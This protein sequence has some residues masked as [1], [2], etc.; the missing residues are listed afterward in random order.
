VQC[1]RLGIPCLTPSR[2]STPEFCQRLAELEPDFLVVAAFGEIL[3]K[4][5]LDIARIAPINVHASLLP[6]LRGAAPINWALIRGHGT[7]GIT[8]FR[9]DEG[10]DTGDIL[11][12]AEVPIGPRETA[13]QLSAKLS[14]IAPA[15]L[16]DT[17][18]GMELGT[19]MPAP[20]D[21]LCATYAPKLSKGNGR[22]DWELRA[23]EVDRFIR[24]VTPWPGAL[25]TFRSTPV[26]I[27]RAAPGPPLQTQA[28]PGT[29]LELTPE[30]IVVATGAAGTL[31][32]ESLQPSSRRPMDARSFAAGYR[33]CPGEKLNP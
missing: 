3:R 33:P 8:T 19:L 31:R 22:V 4:R 14:T 2:V 9:M 23:D 13:G 24:G 1:E 32:L 15:V 6:R 29:I 12:Q 28:E 16:L 5:V 17:L 10:M 7:T 21:A 25:T 20:Q 27:I 26:K 11:L 30:G 18:R